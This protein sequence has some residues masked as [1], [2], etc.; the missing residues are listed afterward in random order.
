MIFKSKRKKDLEILF[1]KTSKFTKKNFIPVSILTF[2]LTFLLFFFFNSSFNLFTIGDEKYYE[3][4]EKNDEVISKIDRLKNKFLKSIN[5]FEKIT[6][7]DNYLRLAVNLNTLNKKETAVGHGGGNFNNLFIT[8]SKDVNELVEEVDIITS[9][10]NDLMINKIYSYKELTKKSKDNLKLYSCIPAIKPAM[11]SI[12]GRQFGVYRHPILK[13]M[14]M[15][16]GIDIGGNRGDPIYASGDGVIAEVGWHGGYG[17]CIDINHGFG[18]KSRYAH[19]SK[20]YVT[21]GQKVTRG[22]LIAG[23]GSTGLSTSNHL[24]YEVHYQG[25]KRDPMLYFFYGVKLSDIKVNDT[26]KVN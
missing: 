20:S 12:S 23:M 22:Q 11:G 9:S 24:H 14:R 18:Y 13:T 21:V 15:H 5:K 4:R 26:T 19:L 6:E 8:K 17:L 7:E 25:V 2:L 10:L 16:D 3:L 1:G